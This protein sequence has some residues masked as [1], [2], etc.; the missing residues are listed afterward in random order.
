[1]RLHPA[2]LLPTLLLPVAALAQPG[3]ANLVSLVNLATAEVTELPTQGRG[4]LL[5]A[6]D[7]NFYIASFGGGRGYGALARLTPEGELTTLHSFLAGDEG[8]QPYATLMQASDGNLYGTTYLGGDRNGGTVFRATLS[9]EL[10]TLH[11]F[12]RGKRDARQPYTGLVQAGDGDLYGTTFMGGSE[13]RGVVFRISLSGTYSVV[14]EFTGDDGGSPEGALV[15]GPDGA[16]YGTTLEGGENNRGTIYRLGTDGQLTTLFSFPPLGPFNAE[17]LATNDT[18]TNPRAG[19]TLGADG[20]FYGTAYQGGE[21]G[22]GT[23]YRMTPAGELTVL[24]HFAG[25]AHDGALPTG[26]VTL[27]AAGNLYGTTQQGGMLNRGTAWQVSPDGEFTLLH[28][29]VGSSLDGH[30]PYAGLTLAGGTLHGITY[31]DSAAGR[32]AIFSFDRGSDGV[33]PLRFSVAPETV[34][35]GEGATLSWDTTGAASCTATGSWTDTINVSGTLPVAPAE[36][37]FYTYILNCT[38]G[39]GLERHAFATLSVQAPPREPVDGG[40]GAGSLGTGTLVLLGGLLHALRRRGP[41]AA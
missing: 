30:M 40:G 41:R 36:A 10:T 38:D 35:L 3:A 17:G 23:V 29:F 32:G 13:N 33:P 21:G 9:G 22:K 19:L 24:H 11:S 6:S 5:L 14:H 20:N 18:G 15:A 1:M 37:G 27:D 28:A 25:G 4:D 8:Y 34:T 39:A 31:S 12:D 7:G 16:L 26:G 2:V